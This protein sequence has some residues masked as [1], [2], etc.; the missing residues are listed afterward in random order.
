MQGRCLLG[1]LAVRLDCSACARRLGTTRDEMAALDDDDDT[2]CA[3]P[4]HYSYHVIFVI[5]W[6]VLIYLIYVVECVKRK[7]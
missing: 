4:S 1:S 6:C 3:I 5:F 7:I 2:S